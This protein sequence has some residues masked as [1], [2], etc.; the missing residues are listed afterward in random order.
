M[1][2]SAHYTVSWLPERA[3]YVIMGPEMA[4]PVCFSPVW[5]EGHR[6]FAF[7]GRN[8]QVNLLKEKRRRGGEGYWYAYRRHRGKML[9][10]YVGR[11]AQLSLERLEEIAVALADEIEAAPPVAL[12]QSVEDKL[13]LDND[14]FRAA[15]GLQ[16]EDELHPD[17]R[18]SLAASSGDDGS[19]AFPFATDAGQSKALFFEPLLMSRLQLPRPQKALLAREHLLALLDQGLEHKATFVCGPAGYGKTTLIAQWIA[20]RGAPADF[21]RV[22]SVT[23]DNGDNDPVRFWR[24]VIAACQRFAPELGEEALK[25]LLAHRLPPFQFK[26][27]EM[28]LVALLNDLSQ[29]DSPG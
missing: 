11:D 5:L 24:Y 12:E 13:Y 19:H 9:K 20:A 15:L 25:L 4:E 17:K 10:R 7:H 6:A 1:P 3:E 26:P 27:L 8:G 14:A 21:P 28:V 29:L 18:A 23:L 22:A 16:D 2:K